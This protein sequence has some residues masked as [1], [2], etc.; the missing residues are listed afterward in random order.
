MRKIRTIEVEEITCDIC[1]VDSSKAFIEKCLSCG[2][3]IC[4]ECGYN[5]FNPKEELIGRICPSCLHKVIKSEEELKWI[6]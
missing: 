1:G 3:D 2:H 5:I 6:E 4:H